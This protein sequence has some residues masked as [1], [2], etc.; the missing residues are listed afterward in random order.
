MPGMDFLVIYLSIYLCLLSSISIYLQSYV[1][2][3]HF[4]VKLK[5]AVDF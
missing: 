2:G 1:T 3:I 5:G 4:H